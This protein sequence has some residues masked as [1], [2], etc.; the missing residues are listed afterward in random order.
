MSAPRYT[1]PV[2]HPRLH[3]MLAGF[4][5]ASVASVVVAQEGTSPYGPVD[6]PS[7]AMRRVRA[8]LTHRPDGSHHLLLTSL[9][10][11]RADS[12]RPLFEQL[13]EADHWT[14]QLDGILGLAELQD[15]P[16]DPAL[17]ELIEAPAERAAA[18]RAAIALDLVRVPQAEEMLRWSAVPPQEQVALMSE[19]RLREARVDAAQLAALA[20]DADAEVA[21]EASV[22]LADLGDASAIDQFADR[23]RRLSGPGRETAIV[24]LARAAERHRSKACIASLAAYAGA[25]DATRAERLACL[26]ALLATDLEVGLEIWAELFE[27]ATSNAARLRTAL[28]LLASEQPIPPET[29][30]LMQGRGEVL[31]ALGAAATAMATGTDRVEAFKRILAG[32][33][34]MSVAWA[35]TA[36]LDQPAEVASSIYVSLLDSLIEGR[37]GTPVVAIEAA[38]RLAAIDPDAMAAVLRKAAAEDDAMLE[39]ILVGVLSSDDRAAAGRL[40]RGILGE[41]GRRCDS[42]AI[43]AIARTDEP[44]SPDDL[45]MLAVAAAGGGRLDPSLEVQAAWLYLDRLD[46]IPETLASAAGEP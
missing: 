34:R 3:N 18:I 32:G 41:G 4:A 21:G 16:V 27:S 5:L 13:V 38:S 36:L 39:A 43:L 31:E 26:A 22:L 11:L 24:A 23:T 14:L 15:Q 37:L 17:L 7:E 28:L 46:R 20:K 25:D 12:L 45:E 8:A 19:L 9:R 6:V 2:R 44:L 10:Q 33:H 42:L 40:A 35:M 1:R 30:A 29:F